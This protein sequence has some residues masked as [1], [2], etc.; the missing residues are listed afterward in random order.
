MKD[1]EAIVF[2]FSP[3]HFVGSGLDSLKKVRAMLGIGQK[4]AVQFL[5]F[6]AFPRLSNRYFVSAACCSSNIIENPYFSSSSSWVIKDDSVTVSSTSDCSSGAALPYTFS[7]ITQNFGSNVVSFG[8]FGLGEVSVTE[9]INLQ[10]AAQGYTFQVV[11]SAHYSGSSGSPSTFA[12]FVSFYDSSSNLLE[13]IGTNDQSIPMDNT[14]CNPKVYTWHSSDNLQTAVSAVVNLQGS[15]GKGWA[16]CYGP[17]IGNITL[18]AVY[19]SSC[20]SGEYATCG[21]CKS[22]SATCLS[23]QYLQGCGGT[24]PGTCTSCSNACLSGQYIQGCTGTSAGTCNECPSGS[25]S[26]SSGARFPMFS[27]PQI[28]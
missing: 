1:Q 16:G 23:G 19:S 25:Y 26:S 9:S 17:A 21:V 27:F 12:A 18:L 22:C 15:D 7:A 11:A 20:G 2:L 13:T 8:Y 24:S 6:L 3:V 14:Y 28:C 10:C 5:Y 4:A